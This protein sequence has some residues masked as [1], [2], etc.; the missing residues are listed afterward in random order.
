MNV[1]FNKLWKLLIDKNTTR[2]KLRT[3]A[4]VSSNA[5]AK[6]GKNESVQLE[7]LVKICN[8]LDCTLNDIVEILPE[9]SGEKS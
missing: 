5:M 4:K 6:L 7:V 8:H 2:T 1:S 9:E 3:E